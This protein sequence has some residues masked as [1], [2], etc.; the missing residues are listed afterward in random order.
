MPASS[1]PL[2]WII[3]GEPS[4][5]A[6]A[7]VI[8]TALKDKYP[9][10]ICQGVAGPLTE[11]A[12][13]FVSLFPYTDL[14][15]MGVGSVL[16]NSVSLMR[17]Y[18]QTIDVMH[19]QRPNLLLTIDCP[20]FSLRVSQAV[21]ALTQRVHCV[22]PS[23][24][25]WRKRRAQTLRKKTD[26][27]LHLFEFERH[28]FPQIPCFWVGH[29]L[30]DQEPPNQTLFWLSYPELSSLYPLVC[31]LPGSRVQEIQRCWPI[32]KQSVETLKQNEKNLQA[33]V[34]TLPEHVKIFKQEGYITVT[35]PLLKNSVFANASAALACS[36]TVTL[37]LALHKTP[38][39]IGYKVSPFLAWMLRRLVTT[40]YAGLV[41]ILAQEMVAPEYLQNNFTSQNIT[42]ALKSLLYTSPEINSCH[43]FEKIWSNVKTPQGFAATS[44][45]VLARILGIV[46]NAS[47]RKELET[48]T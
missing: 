19:H 12:G 11:H 37:E 13:E 44:A 3:V 29:P 33:V 1:N 25:A 27:L 32:F 6:L 17:R 36:G 4:G 43:Y 28:F 15:H 2:L 8:L 30:A 31:I 34:V 7:S 39:V 42:K 20:D 26:Y 38:M 10:I 40:P 23:V 35:N 47:Y 24:W 14:C 16:R 22:A 48:V 45:Q 18:R 9:N 5:D 46:E 41:N 21:S